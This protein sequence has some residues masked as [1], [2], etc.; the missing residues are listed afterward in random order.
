VD[1]SA[2]VL[3]TTKAKEEWNI[4]EGVGSSENLQNVSKIVKSIEDVYS[5]KLK[6]QEHKG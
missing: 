6:K 3:T 5:Q 2:R 4:N 1:T